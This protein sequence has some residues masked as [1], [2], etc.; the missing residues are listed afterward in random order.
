MLFKSSQLSRDLWGSFSLRLQQHSIVDASNRIVSKRE[1]FENLF[2]ECQGPQQV[3]IELV[4]SGIHPSY[5]LVKREGFDESIVER[6][7]I[8]DVTRDELTSRS[9]SIARKF[10]V[11]HDFDVTV[12]MMTEAM[13]YVMENKDQIEQAIKKAV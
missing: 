10:G 4:V 13:L 3:G 5:S 2:D 1:V 6:Q 9:V 8:A 7:H 12:K 11:C